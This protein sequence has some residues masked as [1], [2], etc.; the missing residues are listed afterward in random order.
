M[1]QKSQN[2]IIFTIK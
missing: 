1:K 2:E